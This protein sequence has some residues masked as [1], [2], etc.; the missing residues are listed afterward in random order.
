MGHK[1][2]FALAG[3]FALI[4]IALWASIYDGSLEMD[5]YYPLNLW[6]GHEMLLGYAM[7]VVAGIILSQLKQCA[8]YEIPANKMVGL[9]ILWVYGR[10]VPF[11]SELLPDSLIAAIDFVFLPLLF[12]LILKPL[13]QVRRLDLWGMALILVIMLMSNLLIHAQILNLSSGSGLLGLNL[14]VATIVVSILAGAANLFPYYLERA[15]KGVIAMRHPLLD[16]LILASALLTFVIFIS[17]ADGIWLTLSAAITVI[18]NLIRLAG[19]YVQRIWYVPLVWVLFMGY[20]WIIMGFTL[21]ALV[22]YTRIDSI[23]VLHAF[24]VG[25]IGVLTIG[26]MARIS[27]SETGKALKVSNIMAIAFI[28][29][30]VAA[31][32]RVLMPALLPDWYAHLLVVSSYCWLAAFAMFFCLYLP[33]WNNASEN[34]A[35]AE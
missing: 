19:W 27:L 35:L 18:L 12:C 10:V 17:N 33:V 21:M 32:F 20:V 31:V 5:N 7:V 30:N 28:L 11:Y 16:K 26:M 8:G 2:F 24:T 13:M 22:S 29:I 3:L 15:L 1:V 23:I 4:L 6:H 14:S 25:G 34:Q 9:S